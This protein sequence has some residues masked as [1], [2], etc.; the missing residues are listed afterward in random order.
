[1]PRQSET[2]AGI[3]YPQLSQDS[4]DAILDALLF[5]QRNRAAGPMTRRYESAIGYLTGFYTKRWGLPAALGGRELHRGG[6]AGPRRG[7]H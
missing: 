4:I 7:D 5:A 6:L 2:A 3:A 1:M